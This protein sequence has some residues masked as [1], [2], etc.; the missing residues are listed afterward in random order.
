MVNVAIF[1][2]GNGSN[3]ENI[4]NYFL[5]NLDINIVL[6]VSNRVN[7]Y[8]HERAKKLGIPSVT[9][10]KSDFADG[11][12]ILKTLKDYNTDFIVLAGFLLKVP[13][14]ILL[15]YPERIVN[16]HPAL[17]PKYGGKGMYGDYVHQAVKAGGDQQSG[18]T[19]HYVNENYDEGDIIFQSTC[20]VLP[21]DTPEDIAN[22]VHA[23]EYE[24]Y[25]KIVEEIIKNSFPK[26][27]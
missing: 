9:F 26:T 8:V 23:L 13:E 19:I 15:S 10:C 25:P 1:A 20:E 22:K 2:S 27:D 5:N 11:T 7:A 3:A 4:A 6:I 16:I 17:L 12:S 18:I 24:H 14:T 21:T